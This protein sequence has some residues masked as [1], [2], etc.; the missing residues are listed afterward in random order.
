MKDNPKKEEKRIQKADIEA[1]QV[2]LSPIAGV[3]P[4]TYLPAVYGLGLVLILFAALVLP[5]IRR[6]GAELEFLG[7]PRKSAV[8]ID[9]KYAGST[10]LPVFASAGR[11]S[12]RIEK[13]GFSPKTMDVSVPGRIVGSAFFPK[14]HTVEYALGSQDP[15]SILRRAYAEYAAWSLAGKPSAL[16]QAP[17]VLSEAADDYIA[18]SVGA[19]K[20]G[21]SLKQFVSS[22]LAAA[23]S[24][25]IARDG[26]RASGLLATRGLANP[27]G[28][29]ELSRTI[30]SAL[31]PA[32]TASL[33]LK[34]AAGLALPSL[35]AA[36]APDN[37]PPRA[38]IQGSTQVG[39][40][41]FVLFQPGGFG[42][43]F[44]ETSRSQW[45]AFL[46]A[47]PFWAPENRGHLISQGLA[48][49]AYLADW[50]GS[51]DDVP[52]TGVS[53]HAAK[54]YCEWLSE[55]SSAYRVV[56][57]SEAMWEAAASSS[58]KNPALW[59]DKAKAGPMPSGSQGLSGT[60]LSDML[61]NVWEW[62]SDWYLPYPAFAGDGYP[63]FEATERSVRGGS[64]ANAPDSIGIGSRGG[65]SPSHATPFLGFRPAILKK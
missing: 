45:A 34:E 12:I 53:W 10:R 54:A 40:H 25:E 19:A 46:D 57:P 41:R 28:M 3:K 26:L 48:D 16:Y 47:R 15:E 44:A 29:V 11:H 20:T 61:G 1:A 22:A 4:E 50:T 32:S 56:L 30:L 2:K 64:W 42:L 55:G 59:S 43:S 65:L 63:A 36:A 62:T 18:A 38:L 35:D 7:L 6:N 14:R 27:L 5:G 52:V 17:F 60:G 9:G 33:W 39:S 24:P 23:S 58:D 37:T 8:Y 13:P 49:E 31:G 51:R 21:P